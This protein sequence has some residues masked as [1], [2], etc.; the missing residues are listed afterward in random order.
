MLCQYNMLKY[1]KFLCADTLAQTVVL[2]L[3][4]YTV[5]MY[6]TSTSLCYRVI[7]IIHTH[8]DLHVHL[9]PHLHV[10]A[11]DYIQAISLATASVLINCNDQNYKFTGTI[12]SII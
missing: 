12:L 9:I 11:P 8:V 7:D 2:S 1:D 5:E 4:M 10:L 6:A 3:C